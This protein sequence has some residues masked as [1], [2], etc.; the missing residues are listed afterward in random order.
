MRIIP[1]S[2]FHYNQADRELVADISDLG[3][4]PFWQVYCDAIDQGITILSHHTGTQATFVVYHVEVREGDVLY[5]DLKPI[6]TTL[7]YA[8][9]V[10]DLRIRIYND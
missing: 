6:A 3:P 4:N 2:L 7:K 10:A 8:P 9:S 5:W 1:L